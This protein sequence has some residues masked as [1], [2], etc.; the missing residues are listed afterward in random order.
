MTRS[1]TQAIVTTALATV[2]LMG[3]CS[4][5]APEA[6]AYVRTRTVDGNNPIFWTR[7]CIFM[8]PS[9]E[10][11]GGLSQDEVLSAIQGSAD[12][13]NNVDCS[14]ILLVVGA[15]EPGLTAGFDQSHTPKNVIVFRDE[16]WPYSPVAVGLTTITY[17]AST[18]ASSDGEIVDTDVE[19]NGV[20]FD[21]S[22]DGNMTTHD[23]QSVLTHELGHVVGL[24]HTCDDG[25]ITPTPL[26]HTG[27]TIP[28]CFP[29]AQLPL[30]VTE[31]TMYNV[32]VPG[33][34]HKRTLEPDDSAGLCGIFPIADNPHVCEPVPR[35]SN[36]PTCNCSARTVTPKDALPWLLVLVCLVG[37]R[38]R[39]RRQ[40]SGPVSK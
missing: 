8:T 35:I 38:L 13:W 28:S 20:H 39:R 36:Q 34:T 6:Q 21:F 18:R 30:V 14:Y 22:T 17:L 1:T 11:T 2:A 23:L 26:D 3:V 15:P 4:F 37:L 32:A 40:R 24:D 9:I 33:E 5:G 10:G 7:S 27:T 29:Q 19:F 16:T 31:A 25:T 12:A